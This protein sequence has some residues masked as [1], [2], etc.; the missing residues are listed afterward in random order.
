MILRVGSLVLL[1]S[2]GALAQQSALDPRRPFEISDNSFLV[3]EAFNQEAGI[4]QNILLIQHPSAGEWSF[5]FTQEWPL[6]GQRHQLSYTVPIEAVKPPNT[7][8]YDVARGTIALNYRYQLSTEERGGVATS[9]RLSVLIPRNE[10]SDQWGLQL[11]FP[12]SKQFANFYLH[13]NAG[14]TVD[15][16][17]ADESDAR[18]H[19]A[20]S[21]IYRAWPMVHLMVE[22]VY[23][24]NEHETL[25]GREDGWLVSPGLRAGFNLGDHQ[26]VLGAAVPIG[27]LNDNDTQEFIAYISYELPFMRR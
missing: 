5:E 6:F 11:N 10:I 17:A 7:A 4:F 27:L 21:V 8:D 15:G 16:I 9:P 3:E 25:T 1:V 24:A 13:A 14:L 19:T 18:W 2:T 12:L 26:L 23:R 20:A 22:S